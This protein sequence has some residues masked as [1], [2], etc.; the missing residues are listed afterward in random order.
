MQ[1]RR[2][3]TSDAILNEISRKNHKCQNIRFI[4][5]I[6][7]SAFG[8]QTEHW[9]SKYEIWLRFH[10]FSNNNKKRYKTKSHAQQTC[11]KLW[12]LLMNSRII[13]AKYKNHINIWCFW[14]KFIIFI[15]KL[16][17][18]HI[19]FYCFNFKLW[20][21]YATYKLVCIERLFVCLFFFHSVFLHKILSKIGAINS[22]T[23]S[24]IFFL[25]WINY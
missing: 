25:F 18:V 19:F 11:G 3:T 20:V 15:K 4:E 7:A 5:N 23:K 13:N 9:N 21:L 14:L 6:S 2:K 22:N 24:F 10:S 12:E 8:Y 1:Q 16:E 17:C